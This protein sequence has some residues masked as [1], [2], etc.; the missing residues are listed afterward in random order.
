M[1]VA[2]PIGVGQML[3]AFD[4]NVRLAVGL[5]ENIDDLRFDLLGDFEVLSQIAQLFQK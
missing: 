1:H 3:L 2:Q 5:F 4:E